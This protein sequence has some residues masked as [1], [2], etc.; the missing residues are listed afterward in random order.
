ML[1]NNIVDVVKFF[2]FVKRQLWQLH[3]FQSFLAWQ[4]AE[5]ERERCWFVHYADYVQTLFINR[6]HI[7]IFSCLS[8][9][10][11]NNYTCICI[12]P[13]DLISNVISSLVNTAIK[14]T[15]SNILQSWHTHTVSEHQI[16]N[17]QHP[18]NSYTV[19]ACRVKCVHTIQYMFR[20]LPVCRS[21]LWGCQV[22]LQ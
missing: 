13:M 2:F 5:R 3:C 6:L 20:I 19:E 1:F 10:A 16:G 17:E 15:G 8:Q 14:Y 18:V 21:H 11:I 22:V 4:T 12:K 7:V 9:Y